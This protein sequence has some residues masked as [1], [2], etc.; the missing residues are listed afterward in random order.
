MIVFCLSGAIGAAAK[1]W[2]CALR[3]HRRRY[4]LFFPPHRSISCLRQF[5]QVGKH[6]SRHRQRALSTPF[7]SLPTHTARF[8]RFSKT[9]ARIKALIFQRTAY[10]KSPRQFAPPTRFFLCDV[11]KCMRN[12]IAISCL[13]IRIPNRRRCM[14]VLCNGNVESGE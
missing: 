11:E 7:C 13:V 5:W 1:P 12:Q 2:L 9:S 10:S 4:L 8:V 14:T 6:I 3:T